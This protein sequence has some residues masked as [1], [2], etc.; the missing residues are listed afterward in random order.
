MSTVPFGLMELALMGGGC[1]CS[2]TFFVALII[3]VVFVVRRNQ[4]SG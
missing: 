3:G 2:M 1:L 4:S